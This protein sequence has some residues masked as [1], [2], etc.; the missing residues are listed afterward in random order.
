MPVEAFGE[1]SLN[2][3][4]YREGLHNF[5]NCE[6][7][8]ESS[9]MEQKAGS[10]RTRGVGSSFVGRFK[11]THSH[12]ERQKKSRKVG[13]YFCTCEMIFD[14]HKQKE[15]WHLILMDGSITIHQ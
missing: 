6:F 1:A 2:E 7:H 12:S 8:N 4:G 11:E 3:G 5:K 14:R 10:V 13:R 15:F 9:K